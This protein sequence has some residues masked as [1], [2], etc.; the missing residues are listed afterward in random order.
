[1]G[2]LASVSSVAKQKA[3]LTG[4]TKLASIRETYQTGLNYVADA[5]FTTTGLI[6]HSE[7]ISKFVSPDNQLPENWEELTPAIQGNI[8][9]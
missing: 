8:K 7:G 5:I 4:Q 3:I 9:E 1:M 2:S 6:K